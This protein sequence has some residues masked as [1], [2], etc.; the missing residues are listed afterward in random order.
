MKGLLWFLLGAAAGSGIT[1]V[2][3][4]DTYE[5]IAI[6]EVDEMKEYYEEKMKEDKKATIK[7]DVNSK[8]DLDVLARERAKGERIPYDKQYIPEDERDEEEGLPPSEQYIHNDEKYRK[9][10]KK[11]YLIKPEEY[12]DENYHYDKLSYGY[13]V[14]DDVLVDDNED[15]VTDITN[16]IGDEALLSFGEISEDPDIVY[17]RNERL[18]VDIEII[19]M[20]ESYKEVVLGMVDEDDE[21]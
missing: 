9:T 2:L 3:I 14:E 18:A 19:R 17:V 10:M 6:E 13:Y 20:Q 11:P 12:S 8:P 1:Y 15:V 16:T 5:Q 4:K 21:D 7:S